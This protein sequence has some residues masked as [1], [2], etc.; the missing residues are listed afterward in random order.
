MGTFY[1]REHYNSGFMI[2]NQTKHY[3]DT[4]K[5]LFIAKSFVE[6]AAQNCLKF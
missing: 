2:I 4:H 3:L 6:G 1:P 5:R